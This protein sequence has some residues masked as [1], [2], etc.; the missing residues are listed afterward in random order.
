M[1]IELSV[2]YFLS[3]DT[4]VDAWSDRVPAL[5][6]STK[7]KPSRAVA[8]APR[9]RRHIVRGAGASEIRRSLGISKKDL[10]AARRDLAALGI[11]NKK[12]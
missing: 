8:R 12:L 6:Q 10:A 9:P 7:L 3:M 11:E 2:C 4:P 5:A 1:N